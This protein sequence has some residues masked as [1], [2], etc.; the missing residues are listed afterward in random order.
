MKRERKNKS[1]IRRRALRIEQNKAHPLYLFCLI[2][3]EIL[4]ISDISRLSRGNT[5]KLIGYQRPEV[6]R[7]VQNIVE[8][9]NSNDILFP[10]SLILALSSKIN[11]RASRGRQGRD[12]LVVS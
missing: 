2:G 8:Y 7:H 6:K 3:D 10:N 1:V 11:F 5:G 9:L 4:S 12:G